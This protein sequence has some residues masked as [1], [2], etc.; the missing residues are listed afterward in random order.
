MNKR[1]IIAS[2]LIIVASIT[3]GQGSAGFADSIRKTYLIPELNYSVVSSDS[4][5]EIQSLGYKKIGSDRK[6]DIHDLFRIGSNTKAIT[7][8]IAALM[9]KQGKIA[10]NTRFFDLF[11][12]LKKNSNPAYSNLNL[13]DLL[14]FRTRLPRY[15]YTNKYPTEDQFTGNEQQQRYQFI[16]WALKQKPVPITKDSMSYSN[17]GYVIAGLM[18]EKVSG[19]PYKELVADLGKKLNIH[20]YFGQPN[21]IDTLQPWGHNEHLIPEPPGQNNKLDWLL[22]AGNITLSL[23]DYARFIQLQLQGLAGKAALLSAN[24]FKL[25][26][27]GR[28]VFS[29]GWFY[30]SDDSGN[31]FT[32]NTGNPGTFLT[33]VYVFG[34][35]NRAIIIFANSQTSRA[36]EGENLL[37]EQL[38]KIYIP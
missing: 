21:N 26:H 23:P 32:H 3:R 36:E 31:V 12:E 25:L 5:L 1:F 4:I 19:K 33:N 13:L 18:L 37:F 11:P 20:F 30:N 38:R 10:W 14:S 34:A 6:S 8:F 15:T 17:L 27:Y 29:L 24:E 35:R 7:G 28:P 9:V 2:L 22:P 16:L